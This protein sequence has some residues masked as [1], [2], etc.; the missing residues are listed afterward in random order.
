[1]FIA[2]LFTVSKICRQTKCPSIDEWI[3]KWCMYTME[4]D[5]AI[6]SHKEWNLAIC[7]N[8]DGARGCCVELN[9][10]DRGRQMSYENKLT[11]RTETDS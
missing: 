3:K 7:N 1:M 8:M 6:K 10:S 11:S 4:Y 9:N 5:L 2:A